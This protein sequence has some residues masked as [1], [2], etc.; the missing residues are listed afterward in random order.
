MAKII[1]KHINELRNAI[2]I[3]MSHLSVTAFRNILSL[4]WSPFPGG[5]FLFLRTEV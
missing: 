4:V 1:E 5:A 2:D 3:A